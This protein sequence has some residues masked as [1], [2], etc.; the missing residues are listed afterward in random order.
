MDEKNVPTAQ[1]CSLILWHKYFQIVRIH[2]CIVPDVVSLGLL[3]LGGQHCSITKWNLQLQRQI[4]CKNFKY[5]GLL[6]RSQ[7]L[8]VIIYI[9]SKPVPNSMS[10]YTWG[11]LCFHEEKH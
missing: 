2:R 4:S 1:L 6:P 11:I 5:Y 9:Q 7:K 8:T 10:H 3:S